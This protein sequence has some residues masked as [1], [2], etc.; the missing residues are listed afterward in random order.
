MFLHSGF[1][2]K[3]VVMF[4]VF[5]HEHWKFMLNLLITLLNRGKDRHPITGEILDT[6]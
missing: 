2:F 3:F 6:E 5:A 4:D 1:L